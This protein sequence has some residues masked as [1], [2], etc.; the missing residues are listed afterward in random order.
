MTMHVCTNTSVFLFLLLTVFSFVSRL[1]PAL[2]ISYESNGCCIAAASSSQLSL[3]RATVRGV[4]ESSGVVEIVGCSVHAYGI[5]L[6]YLVNEHG[7]VYTHEPAKA[8]AF[9][10]EE[11]SRSF[12][13]EDV[14]SA[15]PP[16][17]VSLVKP[18]RKSE[19]IPLRILDGQKQ[20][21]TP[22]IFDVE[23]VMCMPAS[24]C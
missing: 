22:G 16:V 14:C 24:S 17:S 3:H 1:R 12:G 5:R 10:A 9:R 19:W 8:R 20:V 6:D 4:P 23:I 7:K 2:R 18:E 11:P 15:T 13:V 21:A